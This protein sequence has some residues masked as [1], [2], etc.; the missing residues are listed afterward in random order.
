MDSGTAMLLYILISVIVS[1]A[2]NILFYRLVFKKQKRM[3]ANTFTW[4]ANLGVILVV[5]LILI[6][7]FTTGVEIGDGVGGIGAAI[8]FGLA[9][10][11]VIPPIFWIGPASI[12]SLIRMFYILIT[13]KKERE[14]LQEDIQEAELFVDDTVVT[15]S[16][17][18]KIS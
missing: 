16:D 8:G 9:M 11:F 15:T 13:R 10:T 5:N 12:F 7:V 2:T 17:S 4:L 14:I 18:E 6:P 1:L 3:K